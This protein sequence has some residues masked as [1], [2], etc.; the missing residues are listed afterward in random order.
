MYKT[1][2]VGLPTEAEWEFAA[3]G[4]VY[5]DYNNLYS[6]GLE[7]DSL[8]WYA[9]NSG[10][11]P[12]RVG[13]LRPNELGLHDMSGNV[14]EWC[15]DTILKNGKLF[16]AVRGGTWFNERAICRPT[17]RYFIF[18]ESKHFNNGFRIVKDL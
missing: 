8:G 11:H 3:R 1:L 18:P 16:V 6:G 15:S 2:F 17:C 12:H 10:G 9:D 13:T 4:G 14:W 5:G 7:L